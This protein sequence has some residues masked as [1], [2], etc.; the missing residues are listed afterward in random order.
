M[1]TDENHPQRSWRIYLFFGVFAYFVI[2][3]QILRVRPD[4]IALALFLFSLALGKDKARKYV[5]DW[6][7]FVLFWIAYDMMRGVVDGLLYRVH[8]GDIFNAELFLFGGLF[9]GTIPSFWLQ[10]FQYRYADSIFKKIID[11]L[12]G[13]FYSFHFA[14]PLLTGW[15]LWHTANDRHMYY[16]FI[17]TLTVLNV[18]ALTTFLLFPAA[19]P[20]YVFQ[21]GFEQPT[22][23]IIGAAGGLIN[24][25]RMFEMKLFTTIWH[26][27]NPNHFA[28]IPSLHGAYPIAVSFFIFAKFRKF[29][30]LLALYPAA[31]WF[32]AVY[33]NH[34][35]IIDLVI[36]GVYLC[37]AYFICHRILMPKVF[38]RTILK[39]SRETFPERKSR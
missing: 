32:A 22:G 34:H 25:D 14:A 11:L 30:F 4:H 36:G 17:Y 27:M 2:I 21:Q 19:P 23:D 16:R 29:P 24:I 26:N 28:A 12:C 31:T 15:I 8:V 39:D 9:D 35:Y 1:P 37:I 13:N 20:W 7:P 6:I 33:L 38:E 10:E 5:I 3:N 18:M